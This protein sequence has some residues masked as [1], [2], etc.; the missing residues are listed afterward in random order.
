ME[1]STFVFKWST[2]VQRKDLNRKGV[3]ARGMISLQWNE[4]LTHWEVLLPST[5]V[6]TALSRAPSGIYRTEQTTC[7]RPD[8]PQV[9]NNREDLSTICQVGQVKQDLTNILHHQIC[10][11]IQHVKINFPI[12][13]KKKAFNCSTFLCKDF[14]QM[15]PLNM[16]V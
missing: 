12:G 1:K 11:E 3:A 9:E 13:G 5:T 2:T 4:T 7:V 6:K 14:Q 15:K 8:T 10:V 16:V